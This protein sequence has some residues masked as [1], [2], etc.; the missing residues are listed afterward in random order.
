MAGPV[1]PWLAVMLG[2]PPA[3]GVL[4]SLHACPTARVQTPL[5][6]C[7]A[8]PIAPS[9][10]SPVTALLWNAATSEVVA[11]GGG[12]PPGSISVYKA[13]LGGF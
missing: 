9:L 4:G 2:Y 8:T 11:A 5:Q 1:L 12:G 6:A 3:A 10:S 7:S 13:R